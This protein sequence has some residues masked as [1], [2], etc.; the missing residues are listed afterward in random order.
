[1]VHGLDGHRINTWTDPDGCYWPQDLLPSKI[2]TAR[3]MTFGYNAG[4]YFN[5]STL[6]IK[7]HAI[8]LLD[9]LRNKREEEYVSYTFLLQV[10]LLDADPGLLGA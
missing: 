6:G 4:M 10:C 8:A 3:I 9:A 7:E 5:D 1:M 2:P